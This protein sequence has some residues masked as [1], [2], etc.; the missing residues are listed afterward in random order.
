[1]CSEFVLF[2]VLGSEFVLFL[3]FA[4]GVL[5]CFMFEHKKLLRLVLIEVLASKVLDKKRFIESAE[6]AKSA[7]IC[8][9]NSADLLSSADP[10]ADPAM[11]NEFCLL[12]PQLHR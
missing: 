9:A 2:S 10:L 1:M 11:K 7:A 6:D 5:C 12:R 4:C 3:C 8:D